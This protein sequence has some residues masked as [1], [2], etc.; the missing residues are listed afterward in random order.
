MQELDGPIY[1][2]FV[3]EG[4]PV[5]PAPPTPD[6]VPGGPLDPRR[7]LAL[8]SAAPRLARRLREL[9]V[10]IVHSNDGRTNATWAL[11]AK[12]AGAKLLWHNRGN[13]NAA[14]LRFV[15][16]VL[17]DKVVSVSRFSSPKPGVFSAASKNEVIYSPFDTEIMEDRGAARAALLAEFGADPSTVFVGY[18]GAFVER[19]RP[20]LFVDAIAAVAAAA[21]EKNVMGVMFGQPR[22]GDADAV[23]ARIAEHGLEE[24]VKLMGFRSPGSRWIAACDILMVPA[25]EEPLGRTLVEAMLVGTAVV[26]TRSGGNPEA[27]R[28]EETG[29]IV[30]AEDAGALAGA[31]LEVI[32][33]P[34]AVREMVARAAADA[35]SRFG[36]RRHIEA[37]MDIYDD[38]LQGR[39]RRAAEIARPVDERP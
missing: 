24:R 25:F 19:K 8:A 35:R 10:E 27:V 38:L 14:G 15:A 7:L 33:S 1:D 37:I 3:G 21:P 23:R 2:F 6:L 20:L 18:F 32:E 5:Q 30:P 31:G 4:V 12:L 17:A 9:G 13:P 11:P 28:D 39:P 29:W 26:A 36:A 22:D 34:G 16:P